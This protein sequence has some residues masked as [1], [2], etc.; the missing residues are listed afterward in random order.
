MD[1][2]EDAI[3]I[4]QQTGDT[5]EFVVT[6]L[7]DEGSVEMLAVNYHDG[8]GS[9][10]CDLHEGV[11]GQTPM[12][13][14]AT[15]FEGFTDVAIFVFT[16]ED[17]DSE[18][19]ESC[20]A[21]PV[22]S[23]DMVAYYFELS[24]E[25]IC[26]PS[27]SVESIPVSAPS[28]VPPAS[29]LDCYTGPLLQEQVGT[30]GESIEPVE[31]VAMSG[32]GEKVSF[33]V[34][35]K[36]A[37]AGDFMDQIAIR[38]APYPSSEND[39][40]STDAVAHDATIPAVYEATCQ[41]GIAEIEVYLHDGDFGAGANA[42]VHSSCT[43]S[44]QTKTCSYHYVLPC[45]EDLLCDRRLEDL[46]FD[47]ASTAKETNPSVDVLS[48]EHAFTAEDGMTHSNE[49]SE[50]DEDVPYCV[51]TDFPCEG[52]GDNLV[53]VCHYSPRKGYQT[54]CVPESDSEILR[55]YRND[56]CGPCEGGFGDMDT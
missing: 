13:Y 53:Y 42:A 35:N 16:G 48:L 51:S 29:H 8:I 49:K 6:Q 56:Y 41:N 34:S 7:W 43:P 10:E 3:K 55:F 33:R 32:N 37:E 11:N 54:F 30:C 39:C 44:P 45:Q 52:D 22:D 19:C 50:E 5:V 25:P 2:P 31:V 46:S 9:Q 40:Y 21:P 18:K 47:E 12:T 38:F 14:T 24:C 17:Y 15:C 4:V 36:W 26:E 28:P 27:S 23:T 1:L 20:Q